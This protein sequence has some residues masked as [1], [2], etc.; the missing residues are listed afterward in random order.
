MFIFFNPKPCGVASLAQVHEAFLRESNEKVAVKI[1]HP[2]VKSRA[3]VDVATMEIFVKVATVLFPDLKLMWLVREIQRNLPK[4][5]DFRHEAHNADR[6]R[7]MFS[8][9]TY[10]KVPKIFYDYCSDKVLTMEFCEG[11]QI[12]DYQHFKKEGMDVNDVSF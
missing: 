12:N 4:E 5:L 8:H 1:Q 3:T 6:V 9:L 10:L 2:K 7:R 11:A